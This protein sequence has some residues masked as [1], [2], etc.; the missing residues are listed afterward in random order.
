M[1]KGW[2]SPYGEDHPLQTMKKSISNPGTYKFVLDR[3]GQEL[4]LVGRFRASGNDIKKWDIEIIHAAPKTSSKTNI[5]GVVDGNGQAFVNGIIKVLPEA[6]GT[7]AFL[8]ERILLLSPNA[9]AEAIP[10]LE[11]KTDDVKCSHAATIGKIDEEEL[12]YLQSRGI[13]EIQAKEMI[14]EGFLIR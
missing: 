6:A 4:E 13:S 7:N 3:E 1:C 14:V 8:E 5:K 10:N 2:S 11:I 9:K 12:F